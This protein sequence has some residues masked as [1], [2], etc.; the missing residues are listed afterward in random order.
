MRLIVKSAPDT[1]DADAVFT[2]GFFDF[3]ML[4]NIRLP[5]GSRCA[6][7]LNAFDPE[8]ADFTFVYFPGERA[9]LTEKPYYDEILLNLRRPSE[10]N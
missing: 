10:E 1:D 7:V 2:V 4:D 9:S 8:Y 5:E 3:P 6:I